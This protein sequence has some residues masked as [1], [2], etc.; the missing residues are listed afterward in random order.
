MQE[1]VGIKIVVARHEYILARCH[2][3]VEALSKAVPKTLPLYTRAACISQP[4]PRRLT[5]KASLRFQI[6]VF[7]YP[8][9]ESAA[10]T[11]LISME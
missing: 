3:I 8:S 4:L 1:P 11:P 6:D 7:R 2:T 5:Q 9:R 10:K